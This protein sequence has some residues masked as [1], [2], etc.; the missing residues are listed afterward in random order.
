MPQCLG[1]PR[2]SDMN[3][4]HLHYPFA[5][6]NATIAADIS[7]F[8]LRCTGKNGVMASLIPLEDA[9]Q[10]LGNL[11]PDA[12]CELVHSN[13]FELLVAT[14]LSAQTTDVRV[15]QVTRELF[16][17]W[18][19]PAALAGAAESDVAEVVR[20][21]GMGVRRAGQIIG[22]SS[23][24]LADHGGEVPN[25]QRALEALP[26]VGRKTAHVVRG[27]WFGASLLTVDTHVGRLARRFGWSAHTDPRKVETDVVAL[28]DGAVDLTQL[29]HR[30]IFHGRRVCTAK[31]PDCG[32]CPLRTA[33]RPCPQ[34]GV[35][36]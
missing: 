11:Y 3:V 34:I 2:H 31:S 21:L 26:G 4:R 25:D 36:S 12:E 13:A 16:S 27:T 24:L 1:W 18:P 17:R 30:M 29:S 7:L 28:A 10:H 35:A 14:V 32:S 9:V 6:T 20:P 23:G 15:N 33:A 5:V 22:L 19:D 8:A